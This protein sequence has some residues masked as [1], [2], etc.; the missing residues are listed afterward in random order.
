M[1]MMMMSHVQVISFVISQDSSVGRIR[2][3]SFLLIL[4]FLDIFLFGFI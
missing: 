3:L 4:V 2:R 1:M